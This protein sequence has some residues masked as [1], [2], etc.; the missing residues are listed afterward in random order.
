M[1]SSQVH[2]LHVHVHVECLMYSS[3]CCVLFFHIKTEA[4]SSSGN[5]TI[6]IWTTS[7]GGGCSVDY[8]YVLHASCMLNTVVASWQST[9]LENRGVWVR[10]PPGAAHFFLSKGEPSQVVVLCCALLCIE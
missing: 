6:N 7:L 1:Y 4:T 10:I 2:V 8:V 9:R 5:G 3:V